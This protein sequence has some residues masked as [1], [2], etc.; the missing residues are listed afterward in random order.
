MAGE[1][2]PRFLY[3][4]WLLSTSPP[5]ASSLEAATIGLVQV[6]AEADGEVEVNGPFTGSVNREFTL[7]ITGNGAAGAATFTWSPDAEVLSSSSPTIL[8]G[9]GIALQEG[10]SVDFSGDFTEEDLYRFKVVRP[11]GPEQ[12]L[13]GDRDTE[14]R[15]ADATGT[16][17]VD[18]DLGSARAP[19]AF[20]LMDHNFQASASLRLQASNASNVSSLLLDRAIAIPLDEDGAPTRRLVEYLS[21]E[22]AARYW[23]I[24][25]ADATNPHGY[26]RWS[27][28]FLG[29]YSEFPLLLGDEES[30]E[31]PS[32]QTRTDSGR[33][34]GL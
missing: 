7:R 6:E 4:N 32:P 27:E 28:V 18:F 15:T 5:V 22:V 31:R 16:K 17:T 25:V 33:W 30:V 24:A 10:I 23:R 19:Q 1:I 26:L 3:D 20:A 11:H 8:T 34:S 21:G 2:R 12:M 9:S 29:P 14:Y 13:D